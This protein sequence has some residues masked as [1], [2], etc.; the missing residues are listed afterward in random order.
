MLPRPDAGEARPETDRTARTLHRDLRQTDHHDRAVVAYDVDVEEIHRL[1]SDA[2]PERLQVA[3]LRVHLTGGVRVGHLVCEEVLE[4]LQIACDQRGPTLAFE[5]PHLLGS[6]RDDYRRL[7]T[8]VLR[9]GR[10]A[11]RRTNPTRQCR[12][13]NTSHASLL[14]GRPVNRRTRD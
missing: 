7:M 14:R 4:R 6:C 3:L 1:V 10:A 12:Q 2:G 13:K 8:R 11:P 5:L 9:P